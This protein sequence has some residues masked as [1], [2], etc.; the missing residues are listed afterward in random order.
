MD[1]AKGHFVDLESWPRAAQYAFFRDYELPYFNICAD[2]DV[3][4]LRRAC[5]ARKRS[6]SLG[7]WFACQNAVNAVP[8]LRLRLRGARVWSHDQIS[9]AV[10]A[11]NDDDTFRFCYLPHHIDF[12]GFE[13]A[14]RRV[15]DVD[16]TQMQDQPDND[17][18]VHGST[19]PWIRFTSVSHPRRLPATSTVPKITFGKA[20]DESMPVSIEVHHAL[21]DGLHAARFFEAFQQHLDELADWL[22]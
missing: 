20:T 3:S 8:E 7:C 18:V 16:S 10:T 21:V 4:S 14:A 17:A 22:T 13:A 1:D 2:V 6:F 9:V 11:L 5:R 19:L 15:L 12:D